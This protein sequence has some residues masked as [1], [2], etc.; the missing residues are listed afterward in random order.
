LLPRWIHG[1]RP[2]PLAARR[3]N[4]AELRKDEAAQPLPAL[5]AADEPGNG[6]RDDAALL[7]SYVELPQHRPLI[8][9]VFRRATVPAQGVRL[10][11][12]RDGMDT[13]ALHVYRF[14]SVPM[15]QQPPASSLAPASALRRD[16]TELQ[17]A[18]TAASAIDAARRDRGEPSTYDVDPAT[19]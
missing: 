14:S 5:V 19:V 8:L 10:E 3:W 15:P 12:V 7:I 1:P 2:N 16:D 13:G 18:T 17:P 6:A 4:R 9:D 11:R